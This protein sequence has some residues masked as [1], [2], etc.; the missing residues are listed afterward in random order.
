M[1]ILDEPLAEW[2]KKVDVDLGEINV[3]YHEHGTIMTNMEPG[4]WVQTKSG[5][6][7]SVQ[8]AESLNRAQRRKEGIKL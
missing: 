6:Y 3:L 4:G 2:E 8:Y 7:V 1:M 5:S